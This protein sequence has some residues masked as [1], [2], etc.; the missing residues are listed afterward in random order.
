MAR[1][2]RPADSSH[3]TPVTGRKVDV[4][5]DT[6]T[7]MSSP[8]LCPLPLEASLQSHGTDN[9]PHSPTCR[10]SLSLAE[11]RTLEK[12]LDDVS[13]SSTPKT[14]NPLV[15]TEQTPPRSA[16]YS[17]AHGKS[18]LD[19]TGFHA[20]RGEATDTGYE[21]EDDSMELSEGI[22]NLTARL[23]DL[24]SPSISKSER[25]LQDSVSMHDE[26]D[27]MRYTGRRSSV[28]KHSKTGRT[29]QQRKTN[30]DLHG[31]TIED[32][33]NLTGKRILLT[34]SSKWGG[35]HAD[36]QSMS[37]N[38]KRTRLGVE[39]KLKEELAKPKSTEHDDEAGIAIPCEGV[40]QVEA[41]DIE[42]SDLDGFDAD[43]EDTI[44]EAVRGWRRSVG[45]ARPCSSFGYAN[46]H[47]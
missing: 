32:V 21:D 19:D 41:D 3:I 45:K 7:V 26:K 15:P 22:E 39:K 10:A 33:M 47:S 46:N 38:D 44:L 29:E 5:T 43:K 14:P 25:R 17:D 20:V 40:T 6:N 9:S 42:D 30:D 11:R 1:L 24:V 27:R 31:D 35:G 37:E 28:A 18:T 2:S 8:T 12:I 13:N 23:A 16:Q 36:R 34:Q 4:I